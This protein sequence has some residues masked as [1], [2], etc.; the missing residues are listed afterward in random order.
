MRQTVGMLKTTAIRLL[1]CKTKGEAARLI[2]IGDASFSLWPDALPLRLS[3]RVLAV[4]ARRYLPPYLLGL[5]GTEAA[6]PMPPPPEPE[7]APPAG[8]A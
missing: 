4:Q 5:E 2:G 3:D 1:A 8:D 6:E 7:D